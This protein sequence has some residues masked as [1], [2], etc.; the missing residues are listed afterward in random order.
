MEEIC[1]WNE[2]F[3]K[4]VIFL[5]KNVVTKYNNVVVVY[6]KTTAMQK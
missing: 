5:K 2:I 3:I 6:Y 4:R 1:L